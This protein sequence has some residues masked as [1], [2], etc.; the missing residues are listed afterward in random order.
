LLTEPLLYIH[1]LLSIKDYGKEHIHGGS[2]GMIWSANPRVMESGDQIHT[3][4]DASFM[5]YIAQFNQPFSLGKPDQAWLDIYNTAIDSVNGAL[6]I[7]KPGIT[8]GEL[9]DAFLP[10]IV[11]AG[12]RQQTP[13]FHGIGLAIEEPFSGFPAQSE[14]KAKRDRVLEPNMVIEFEPSVITQDFRR[15]TTVGS[16]ILITETRYRFL[17]K[18]W[19]PEV[20][21]I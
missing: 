2:S 5:G 16:P 17:S 21:I 9:N 8:V 7:L 6:K 12:Y 3:E 19:R 11:K 14:Y 13:N 10:P 1:I 20:T 15:G 4:F 18:G